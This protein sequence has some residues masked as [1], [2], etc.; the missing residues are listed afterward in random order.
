MNVQELI[1]KLMLIEDKSLP[2]CIPG[3]VEEFYPPEE[4]L[5]V[6]I[7]D[8]FYDAAGASTDGKFVYL[9]GEV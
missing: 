9:D 2:V 3:A 7:K 5:N 6:T 1:D 8:E 4:V